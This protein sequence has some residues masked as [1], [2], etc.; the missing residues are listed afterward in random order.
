[1]RRMLLLLCV[2]VLS[3]GLEDAHA[4]NP[5]W[6]RVASGLPNHTVVL[7]DFYEYQNEN[8]HV[9]AQ[10]P[11]I[12]GITDADVQMAINEELSK[13]V[14][15]FAGELIE[16]AEEA[17][18]EFSEETVRP[19]FLPFEGI[20]EFEVTLNQGGLLSIVL[21]FYEFT[22]GAHGMTYLETINIDLTTGRQLSF[23]DVFPNSESLEQLARIV[24]SRIKEHP[25]WFF[26]DEFDASMFG[27]EQQFYLKDGHVVVVFG[28]Y[29]IAPYAAGIQE[30]ALPVR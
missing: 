2:F 9:R 6:E 24:D 21:T 12:W 30:F 4:A 16:L 7:G 10:T 19:F 5:Y 26:I 13:R 18:V 17:Y 14:E 3:I 29:E 27:E 25:D 1:V 23:R 28:L 20:A 11:H 8:V 15:Q 22:G